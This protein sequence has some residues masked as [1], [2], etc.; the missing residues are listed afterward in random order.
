MDLAD[1]LKR[2]EGKTLE[3]RRDISTPDG[4]LR[5]IVAFANSTDGMSLVGIEERSRRVRRSWDP[6]AL[7]ERIAS[8]IS[9]RIAPRP[10]PEIEIP[11]WRRTQVLTIQVYPSSSRPHYMIRKEP[12]DGVYVRVGS[13]NRW[14]E[15]EL[16][17][18]L[19]RFSRGEIF[20][21]RPM[22]DIDS[23]AIDFRAISE[24]IATVR[25]L[26]RR[27]LET[28]RLVTRYQAARSPRWAA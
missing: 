18:E 8:L 24:S 17:E 16:I 20:D 25:K 14:A 6:L 4:A 21:E 5:T 11:A 15:A 13:N 23:E 2:P 1:L 9:N 27:D 12:V 28:L 7:E 3:M 19:R 10:V 26:I 22:P